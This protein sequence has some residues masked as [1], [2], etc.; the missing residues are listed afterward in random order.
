MKKTRE[1]GGTPAL[2]YSPTFNPELLPTGCPKIGEE[3][4]FTVLL[5]Y[6]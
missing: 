6:F 4:V 5:G 3:L 1:Q 2:A